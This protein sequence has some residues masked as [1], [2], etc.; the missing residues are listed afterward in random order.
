MRCLGLPA[1]SQKEM[2]FSSDAPWE[3]A[4]S[5]LLNGGTEVDVAC[6]GQPHPIIVRGGIACLL[7]SLHQVYLQS[8][9]SSFH[10]ALV[11]YAG[12]FKCSSRKTLPESGELSSAITTGKPDVW[13]RLRY[14]EVELVRRVLESP[15]VMH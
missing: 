8:P 14:E 15:K 9:Y 6:G 11:Q 1:E 4:S 12:C 7:S 13:L 2:C 3:P 5:S 10:K